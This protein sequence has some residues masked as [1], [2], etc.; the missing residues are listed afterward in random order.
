MPVFVAGSGGAVNYYDVEPAGSP[1]AGGCAVSANSLFMD[2]G[3]CSPTSLAATPGSWSLVCFAYR[4][5]STLFFVNGATQTVAGGQ[6]DPYLLSQIAIGSNG[7]G[8]STTQALFKGQVDEVS[9]WSGSLSVM[10]MDAL[11]NQGSG[12]RIR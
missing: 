4:G 6:Y 3:A 7:S 2:N 10:D 9:I 5:S 12:C 1:T 8:G 11:Y